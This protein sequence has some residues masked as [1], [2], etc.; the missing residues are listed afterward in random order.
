VTVRSAM[1]WGS[2][3][4][5]AARAYQG[6]LVPGMFLALAEK[7]VETAGPLDGARVLDVAC[8]TGSLS[9]R[10]TEAGASVTGIDLAPP[11]V[12]VARELSSGIAFVEGS[13]DEL[14]FPDDSFDVVTCQQGPAVLP[15]PAG[16]R[17]RDAARA[18]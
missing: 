14:P 7:V 16:R 17:R 11:M 3:A 18:A 9:R 15:R 2:T 5:D 6:Y 10:L 13:A 12:A 8:G 1:D 4:D